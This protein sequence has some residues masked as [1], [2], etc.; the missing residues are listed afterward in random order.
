MTQIY[1]ESGEVHNK[2][3]DF[4]LS[5]ANVAHDTPFWVGPAIF[6]A[7][8]A[9]GL[10]DAV[11]SLIG[12]EIYSNP[13][14]HV[15]IKV[16]EK[17]CPRDDEGNVIYGA[18]PWHQDCG[19][20]NPEADETD[21]IT[22]WFP[23]MDTDEENGCLQVVPGSHRGEDMLTHW[24][25]RKRRAGQSVDTGK[26]VRSRKSSRRAAEKGRRALLHKIHSPLIVPEQQR[27]YPL[28]LRPPLQPRRTTNW[29]ILSSRLRRSQQKQS[30]FRVARSRQVAPHVG[31]S[32]SHTRRKPS[33]HLQPLGRHRSH[34]RVSTPSNPRPPHRSG[35]PSWSPGEAG[36]YQPN[37]HTVSLRQ[38]TNVGGD[39]LWSPGEV[40][41]QHQ[42]NNHHTHPRN[43]TQQPPTK[44]H[45]SL[46]PRNPRFRQQ[47]VFHATFVVILG[48]RSTN[49]PQCCADVCRPRPERPQGSREE[50]K[51]K[52]HRQRVN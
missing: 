51:A 50:T 34:L 31:T 27:P 13:V 42:P 32:P 28:E 25:R 23:L 6:N 4:T 48:I 3:F 37:H 16:P 33:T 45:Q 46:N 11:E 2:Y 36:P 41:G 24:P 17:D 1:A 18:A 15:R 9:P 5:V 14:Q 39:P 20:V 10:L 26:R 35:E 44:S 12:P 49:L 38:P 19:V 29:S 7:L 21:M 8:T 22:V 52:R 30:G 47:F 43:A 40:R